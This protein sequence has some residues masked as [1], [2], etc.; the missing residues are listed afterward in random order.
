M[1][2]P[3]GL[4]ARWT[5][6]VSAIAVLSLA[7]LP[8]TAVGAPTVE[9]STGA[10]VGQGAA[11]LTRHAEGTGSLYV[12][13]RGLTPGRW[14]EHLWTG[15]CADLGTRVAVLPGLL[16]PRS[17]R[18]AR[19][20]ALTREQADGRTLQFVRGSEVLCATFGESSP[21][22]RP[23]GPMESATVVRVVDGDTIVVDRGS[24]LGESLRYIGMDTP[25]TV[26]PRVPVQCMGAEAAAA[27]RGLVE[28]RRVVL[29]LDVSDRDVFGRLL[30]HVW[31]QDG[32]SWV[33]V[34]LR[35]VADGYAYASGYPPDVKYD[36]QMRAA[37]RAAEQAGRGLWAPSACAI[38]TPSPTRTPR[39]TLSP[40]P[41]LTPANPTRPCDPAYPSVCIPPPPPDLD[42]PD[43]GYRNFRVLAP[44]PHRFDGDHDGIGCET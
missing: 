7:L 5:G 44:D 3:T 20:N 16:V 39:P 11:R 14:N 27:N 31:L 13:L 37:Q 8:G 34:G 29:E 28:G 41:T 2:L 15:T 36:D 12:N 40:S 35:L 42:C 26:D 32:S 43:V 4:G 33:L 9:S 21:Q 24:G 30:R 18:I 17:G 22:L 25:E 19:T 38:P 23:T 1:R 10:R 6:V